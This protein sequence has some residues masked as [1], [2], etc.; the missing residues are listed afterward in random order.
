MRKIITSD[1]AKFKLQKILTDIEHQWTKTIQLEFA[2]E[3]KK[4]TETL[5][6]FPD[7]YPKS[8]IL[9]GLHKCIISRQTSMYY[10]FDI[11]NIYII[12][13]TDNRQ[14]PDDIEKELKYH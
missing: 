10:K 12:N 9:P 1:I 14:N 13:F 8:E 5:K 4:I 3:L 2:K 6:I 11:N 7:A